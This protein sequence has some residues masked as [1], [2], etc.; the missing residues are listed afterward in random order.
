MRERKKNLLR[1][2]PDVARAVAA[3][4]H[5]VHKRKRGM[6]GG[7]VRGDEEEEEEE[8]LRP[9]DAKQVKVKQPASSLPCHVCDGLLSLLTLDIYTTTAVR[10][11]GEEVGGRGGGRGGLRGRRQGGRAADRRRGPGRLRR[12]SESSID[13]RKAPH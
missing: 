5:N 6:A 1:Y 8:G 9:R 7:G 2:T 3:V 10:G 11:P 12:E 4:L 13:C